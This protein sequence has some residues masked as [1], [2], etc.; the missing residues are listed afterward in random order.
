MPRLP[1]LTAVRLLASLLAP[2]ALAAQAPATAPAD[3]ARQLP[4][5]TVTADRLPGDP[6]RASY[7]VTDLS[8]EDAVQRRATGLDDALGLV[9]G[10]L[11]QSRAGGTDVRLVIR[12]SGARGAGDRSNAGTGRGVRLLLDGFPETEPD[13]RTAFDLLDVGALE[14][15][16]VV[17][18]N[19]STLFGNAAGGVVLLSTE[20]APGTRAL[21]Q[22][23]TAG[24][25]GLRRARMIAAAPVGQG[26]LWAAL[27]RQ[28]AG[29]W[30][31]NSDAARWFANVGL[32]APL[33]ARTRGSVHLT[34]AD[35]RFAIPG[36]LTAEALAATPEAANATYAARR[37][38]RE[39]L[40]GRLGVTLLH[41]LGEDERLSISAFA[42]PKAL[43][44]SE[45]GTFREFSRLHWG[46]T[47]T[48]GRDARLGPTRVALLAGADLATQDG[49][50]RFWTLSATGDQGPTLTTDKREGATNTGLFAQAEWAV[51]GG[52]QLLAG[53]RWDRITY[54]YRDRLRPSL[55]AVRTLA[56]VNP[57]AGLA[58]EVAPGRLVYANLAG[59]VEAPAGNEVDPVGTFGQ[60]T[61]TALNPLL[62]P[63][64]STTWE[65]GTRQHWSLDG[66]LRAVVL[67]MAAYRTGVT[68][69]LV[70]YRGG[71]FHLTAGRA[72]RD[73]VEL[74][75]RL[76]V[77]G[78]VEL[79]GSLA[80]NRHSYLDYVVDSVHYGR[81][82]RVADYSG[83]R[84]VGVPDL[85][86]AA[87]LRWRSAGRHG[88]IAAFGVRGNGRYFADDANRVPVDGFTI[89]DAE[90]GTREPVAL[91]A[92]RL[93]VRLGVDNLA[94]RRYTASAFLNPDVV[95]G[96]PVAFEPGLPRNAWVSVQLGWRGS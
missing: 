1:L 12:G 16:R 36:P 46:G 85:F 23:V 62:E 60:D 76:E 91:G 7:A 9:P 28:E 84:V 33:G 96:R 56:R 73:G 83:N 64:T 42:A 38:R 53:T 78:G 70:P 74:G 20:P 48:W 88:V 72:R 43:T 30:R 63:I 6:S 11:A 21:D 82:G 57:R 18:T 81:P 37:E 94:D 34:G 29:G 14:Q 44:R 79:Q 89:L 19:A 58:W 10:V 8:R 15:V 75:L 32:A 77:R 26:Q 54:D 5:I 66:P 13:G 35:A 49:P 80:L 39:N 50:A 65:V 25:F 47:V 40:V 45:R 67:D 92:V 2:C 93:G 51:G 61:V 27:V 95:A 41:A 17:R 3:T 69:E 31:A 22:E 87:R 55:D 90:L 24:S 86:G 52:V 68:N 71:R 59:G 4:P